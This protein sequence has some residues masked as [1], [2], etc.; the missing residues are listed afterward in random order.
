MTKGSRFAVLGLT[1]DHVW[2]VLGQLRESAV[3]VAAADAHWQLLDRVRAE[4]GCAIYPD[5]AALLARESL[6]AV[7]IY[8]DNAA[9]VLLTE[10]AAAR[11]L[12]IL[13]EKPLAADLAGAER[14]LAAVRRAGVRLMVNWPF[15]WWPQLQHALHLARSG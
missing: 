12:H 15:A 3:L 2:D 14:M 11:G 4:H 10:Q 7:Y 5:A 9:G 6:D 8:A 1:H 13:T